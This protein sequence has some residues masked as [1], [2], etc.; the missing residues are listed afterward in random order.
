MSRHQNAGENYS[1][2]IDNKSFERV[3]L[4]KYLEKKILTNQ[5]SIQEENKSTL[6]SVTD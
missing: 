4:F 3:E 2:K 1:I 6:K 5:N